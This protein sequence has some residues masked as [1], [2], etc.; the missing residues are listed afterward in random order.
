MVRFIGAGIGL[1]ILCFS[2]G[3]Y[4]IPTDYAEYEISATRLEGYKLPL[5]RTGAAVTVISR[6]DIDKSGVT[7]IQELLERHAG[8]NIFDENGNELEHKVSMRGFKDG[9]DIV[10]V[11]DGMRI[12]DPNGNFVAWNLIPLESIDRIEVV[13]GGATS[14]YGPYALSGVIKIWT[15]RGKETNGRITTGISSHA[16]RDMTVSWGSST[17]RIDGSINSTVRHGKGYR[18]NSDFHY[19]DLGGEFGIRLGDGRYAIQLQRHEDKVGRAGELTE[20]AMLSSRQQTVKP[21]DYGEFDQTRIGLSAQHPL[22]EGELNLRFNYRERDRLTHSTS[23]IFGNRTLT[24]DDLF[25]RAGVV[26]WSRKFGNHGI[27][28][29][30][31]E[32]YDNT[33]AIQ[34]NAATN[35]MMTNRT[36]TERTKSGAARIDLALGSDWTLTGTARYDNFRISNRD[37]L[38]D[39]TADGIRKFDEFSPGGALIWHPE[40][41]GRDG[42]F[43]V[44]ASRGYKPPNIFELYAFPLWGSNKNLSPAKSKTMEAGIFIDR[45]KF[46]LGT[47]LFEIDMKDEIY[48]DP[49]TNMNL[50]IAKTERKGIETYLGIELGKNL[51]LSSELTWIAAKTKLNPTALQT[52]GKHI[53]QVPGFQSSTTL[54]WEPGR[55]SLAVTHRHVGKQWVDFDDDNN[56]LQL[57]SYDLFDLTASYRPRETVK[58]ELAVKNIGGKKYVSRGIDSFDGFWNPTVYYNPSPETEYYGSLTWEF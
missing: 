30:Y 48:Y 5:S 9:N 40:P 24:S 54:S 10:V 42:K 22:F 25:S 34:K 1:L 39:T 13:R 16:G 11:L 23:I 21:L 20:G 45:D 46:D 19:E 44:S 14:L 33:L 18:N 12:N 2:A 7:T 41:L 49:A 53:P 8:F 32:K 3:A 31:D 50:N 6:E 55:Y 47:T 26:E 28:L 4:E 56:M 37:N 17:E 15:R 38:G 43:F 35:A 27:S 29:L 36:I 51:S 52:E 58:L 57:P